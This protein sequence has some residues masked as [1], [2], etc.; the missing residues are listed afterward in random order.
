MSNLSYDKQQPETIQE[1]FGSI[2]KRYDRANA[3]LSFNLH[4]YWN[5]QLVKHAVAHAPGDRYLDLCSGTGDIAFAIASQAPESS[6]I[7]LLDFCGE[8]LEVAQLKEP[9]SQHEFS[10]LQGDAQQLPFDNDSFDS[11]T[12]SYGIR[13]VKSPQRCIKECKRVL[14]KGGNLAVLELTR[15]SH[16]VMKF[17]H[18]CYLKGIL[19][20]IGKFVTDNQQ[21]YEYLCSSIHHFTAPVELAQLMKDEGFSNV[22]ITPLT[23]GIATLVTASQP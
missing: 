23:G 2:A 13:N 16:P 18:Q 4:K 20:I 15:P 8:M 1:M 12:I 7:C 14:S 19:P 5:K 11:I 22:T 10:Y 9:K 3:V 21:A 17:G 6:K